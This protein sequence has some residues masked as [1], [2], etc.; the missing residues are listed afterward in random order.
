MVYVPGFE[1][2]FLSV[3]WLNWPRHPRIDACSP[4]ASAKLQAFFSSNYLQKK[5]LV[6]QFHAIHTQRELVIFRILR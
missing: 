3:Q 2:S 5:I 1:P 6:T 4:L